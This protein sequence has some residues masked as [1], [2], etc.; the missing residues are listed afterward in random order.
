MHVEIDI[1]ERPECLQFDRAAVLAI[2]SHQRREWRSDSTLQEFAEVVHL[3]A[4]ARA[5]VILLR[6]APNF[7]NR[8]HQM[9][10]ANLFSMRRKINSP[11]T[12]RNT[13][14]ASDPPITC[15]EAA[16]PSR[17]CRNPMTTPAMGFSPISACHFCGT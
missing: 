8:L 4:T 13:L 17:A 2:F 1:F 11:A 15:H 16:L 14:V 10:S 9:M 6:Q 3:G 5:Q 7:Q 12:N